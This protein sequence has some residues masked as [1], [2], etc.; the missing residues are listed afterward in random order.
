MAVVAVLALNHPKGHLAANASEPRTSASSPTAS[1]SSS[2]PKTSAP[3]SSPTNSPSN[4]PNPSPTSPSTSTAGSGKLPLVVLN[5]TSTTTAS[6]AA[7]RFRQGGWTVT[8]TSTFAGS[9]LSTAAYYDPNVPG[10]QQAAEALQRQ[11]PAIVRVKEKFDG[12][13]QGPI[14][15]VLT[16]DYS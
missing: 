5:N 4:T 7:D 11:F 1:A 2:K 13:P 6:T 14:V 10:A 16:S 8:D 15:I 12:L 3:K 9:I